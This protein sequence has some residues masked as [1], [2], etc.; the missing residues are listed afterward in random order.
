MKSIAG[1]VTRPASTR[2]SRRS[3]ST[4]T[5]PSGVANA[6]ALAAAFPSYMV[7]ARVIP[8]A[9]LPRVAGGKIDLQALHRRAAEPP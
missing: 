5:G 8:L 6:A 3:V 2:A 4:C 9:A 7:P 1:P